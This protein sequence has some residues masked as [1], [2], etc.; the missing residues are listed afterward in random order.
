MTAGAIRDG[1]TPWRQRVQRHAA[2]R[3]RE[4]AWDATKHPHVVT[5]ESWGRSFW[6][7]EA[8]T[9]ALPAGAWHSPGNLTSSQALAVDLFLGLQGLHPA[10]RVLGAGGPIDSLDFE[11]RDPANALREVAPSSVDVRA[12]GGGEFLWEVKYG[13]CEPQGCSTSLHDGTCARGGLNILSACPLRVSYGTAYMEAFE[14]EGPFEAAR[15]LPAPGEP[16]PLLGATAF[17]FVRLVSIAA[18][19]DACRAGI[20]YPAGNRY[21]ADQAARVKGWL[22][23]PDF[24]RLHTLE[25]IASGLHAE[26]HH[27]FA[28]WLKWRWIPDS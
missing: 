17:Q 19:R 12:S 28:A 2:S 13:E 10:S 7:G 11:W 21:I 16:C 15:F 27:D 24:L 26:G 22:K 25:E 4:R 8:A 14:D 9:S 18:R 3:V 20:I 23:D 1:S 6:T 5:G